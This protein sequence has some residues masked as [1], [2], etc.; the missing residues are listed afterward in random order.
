[1]THPTNRIAALLDDDQGDNPAAHPHALAWPGH[2]ES[3][4][5]LYAFRHRDR[6]PAVGRWVVE[7][8]VAYAGDATTFEFLPAAAAPDAT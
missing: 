8:P 2:V 5:G 1:M 6:C 4:T 3:A 7:D